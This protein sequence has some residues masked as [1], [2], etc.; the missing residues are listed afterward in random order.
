MKDFPRRRKKVGAVLK[1]IRMD[2]RPAVFSL[3]GGIKNRFLELK[4]SNVPKLNKGE[5]TESVSVV[6]VGAETL[7]RFEG[8]DLQTGGAL[9]L[10]TVIRTTDLRG[11]PFG[12]NV[13]RRGFTFVY[14]PVARRNNVTDVRPFVETYSRPQQKAAK[15][16]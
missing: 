8:E 11:V 12:D 6:L 16:A 5:G 13:I 2:G 4:L 9:F 14:D 15:A 1:G 3:L 7:P 10:L